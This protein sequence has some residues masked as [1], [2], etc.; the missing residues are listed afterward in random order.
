MP[1]L[2]KRLTDTLAKSLPTPE[3]PHE[4][5]AVAAGKRPRTEY[6]IHWCRDTPGFGVRIT[7]A[8]NRAWIFERRVDGKTRRRTLGD[9]IG[10]DAISA[11]E[12]R[13]QAVGL[14]ADLQRGDDPLVEKRK[15]AKEARNEITF[16]EALRQYCEEKKRAKDGKA[17]KPSTVAGYLH[18]I[19]GDR[20]SEWK[21]ME[22]MP[23]AN[24]MLY[25]LAHKPINR[26]TGDDI[27]NLH[28]E[29]QKRGKRQPV[30]AMQVLRAVLNWHGIKVP[31]NPFSKDVPGRDR[32]TL[33]QS[34]GDPRPVPPEAIGQF[35]RS[36][37]TVGSRFHQCAAPAS[38]IAFVLLTG[39]RSTESAGNKFEDG[40]LMEHVHLAGGRI[41]LPDT[42]NRK[43]HTI[44]L[45]RQALRIV[46]HHASGKKPGEPLFDVKDVRKTL[47]RICKEAGIEA[48]SIHEVRK[49]FASIAEELVSGYTL[50]R[51]LNHTNANDVTG[52]HYIGKSETQLRA[53]WQAVAD[54][55][56]EQSRAVTAARV[57]EVAAAAA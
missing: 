19:Q 39:V 11:D 16:A 18:F 25:P 24:G 17:L 51:M 4:G 44:H 31:D 13:R 40:I 29:N 36:V 23:M 10:R 9:V 56:D 20:V 30:L 32:I 14:S 8:G 2:Q 47:T 37:L 3:N 22:G 21:P 55:L 1:K 5:A 43:N 6:E 49:T 50:K 7:S 38:Y 52:T 15:R 42:K 28:A 48:R 35:W 41:D 33:P 46:K 12:A 54:F 26:I 34:Q 57:R 53:G 45:S 27:R